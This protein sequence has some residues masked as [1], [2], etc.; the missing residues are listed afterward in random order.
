MPEYLY[1]NDAGAEQTVFRVASAKHHEVMRLVEGLMVPAAM[2]DEGP[3]IYR[4][5]FGAGLQVNANLVRDRFGPSNTL[6]KWIPG[7][8]HDNRGRPIIRN[9]D[10]QKQVMDKVGYA[11]TDD[12]D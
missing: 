2:T 12:I 6:P 9:A 11:K 10:H 4:R 8:E 5:V 7:E 3:D 1:R